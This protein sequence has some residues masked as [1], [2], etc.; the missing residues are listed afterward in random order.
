MPLSKEDFRVMMFYDF[1]R[2]LNFHECHETLV[3]TFGQDV[4]SAETV[5]RW[6][7]EFKH[8]QESFEDEPRS[9]RPPTAVTPE[10]VQRVADMIKEHRNISYGEIEAA[11]G[12]GSAAVNSILHE[13]LGVRKLASRWIPHLLSVQQKQDRVDWCKFMLKRFDQCRSKSVAEIITGDESWIYS[14]DPETKQ[15][16]T[17]WVFEDEPSP[18]KV[19]R[20]KSASKQMVAVFFHQEGLVAVVPLVERRTVNAQWYCETCLPVVFDELRRQRPKTGV[21]GILLHHDNAPA[22]TAAQTLDFLHDEGV[23][24]VTHPLYSPDL[25]PSDFYLFP[26]LKKHLRGKRYSSAEEAVS[27]MNDVLK[28]V[29]KESFQDC[30]QKWFSRMHSCIDAHGCYFEKE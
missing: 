2:G 3:A 24:L 6:Y 26:E 14:Y 23:Q 21:R 12:I 11:L 7:H 20:S 22:H 19:V 25:A 9:G 18:T 29:P 17:V 30:F 13:H 1:K 16:S 28:V 15:Q 27:A 8:G 4:P 10:N 5:R